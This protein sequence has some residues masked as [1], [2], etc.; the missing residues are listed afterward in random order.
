[1][2]W[3]TRWLPGKLVQEIGFQLSH[4]N[5]H[6]PHTFEWNTLQVQKNKHVALLMFMELKPR[7]APIGR[8]C[9]KISQS[10]EAS[11]SGKL[12]LIYLASSE[13]ISFSG[14]SFFSD[15]IVSQGKR[16]LAI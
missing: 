10:K 5:G 16:S 3:K 1:M 15:L 7:G 12:L 2:R 4:V 8:S 11:I 14:K 9:G 6:P 13:I